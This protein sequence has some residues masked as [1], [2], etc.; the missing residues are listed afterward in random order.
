VLGK[1]W[2]DVRVPQPGQG[3]MFVLIVGDHLHHHG[4]IG[5]G[6]VGSK[7]CAAGGASAQ[8]GKKKERAEDLARGGVIDELAR[9]SDQAI[10]FE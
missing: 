1:Q 2:D 7:K 9:R 3:Q 4:P 6:R 5:K 10:A 8:L